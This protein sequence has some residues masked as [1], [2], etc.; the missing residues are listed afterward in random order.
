MVG[1][2]K[3]DDKHK[4]EMRR[5]FKKERDFRRPKNQKDRRDPEPEEPLP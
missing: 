3:Y 1:L 2:N 5:K 4:R